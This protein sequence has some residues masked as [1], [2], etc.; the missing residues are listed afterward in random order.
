M[1]SVFWCLFDDDIPKEMAIGGF[2]SGRN[3]GRE[4]VERGRGRGGTGRVS[5]LVLSHHID[6]ID[7]KEFSRRNCVHW[8]A[9]TA[10]LPHPISPLAGAEVSFYYTRFIDKAL[11]LEILPTSVIGHRNRD[12]L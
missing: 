10:N 8:S 6:V 9:R 12:F 4:I 7:R 11:F 1:S 3:V 2:K 5:G